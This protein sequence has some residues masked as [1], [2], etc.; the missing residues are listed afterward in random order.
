MTVAPITNSTATPMTQRRRMQLRRAAMTEGQKEVR[1]EK[2]RIRERKR[3]AAMTEEQKEVRRTKA[4]ERAR[5]IALTKP[6]K[7]RVTKKRP[8][9]DKIRPLPNLTTPIIRKMTMARMARKIG[10][11]PISLFLD[12]DAILGFV[13]KI[14]NI[15]SKITKLA[16]IIGELRDDPDFTIPVEKY[17]ARMKILHQQRRSQVG[18]NQRSK[19]DLAGWLEW[20]AILDVASRPSLDKFE[21][22]C[23][24]LYTELPP[25]RCEYR[26]LFCVNELPKDLTQ[27]KTANYL[28]IPEDDTKPAF[29]LLQKYKTSGSKGSYRLDNVPKCVVDLG[30]ERMGA[31][32]FEYR[33]RDQ[34]AFS[35]FVVSIFVREAGRRVS[36]NIMRKSFV[37][38]LLGPDSP[39]VTENKK[40]LVAH[41]MGTSVAMLMTAYRKL[42]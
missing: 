19:R 30:R 37:S 9:Q 42:S 32:L 20:P 4:R 6:R 27:D 35:A 8:G 16:H 26:S 21:R 40:A 14:E 36:I 13:A 34:A 18:E 3:T 39:G 23:L 33:W 24:A 2:A 12:Y 31:Y 38:H 10:G 7:K 1:R 15:N 29:A 41:H 17:R 5:K 25:R 22:A 11:D 28:V